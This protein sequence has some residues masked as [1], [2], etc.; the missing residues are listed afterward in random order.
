MTKG[1]TAVEILVTVFVAALLLMSGYQLHSVIIRQ[2]ADTRTMSQASN[3]GYEILR[4][5]SYSAVINPCSN[6]Q[7]TAI[8]GSSIPANGLPAPVSV[9]ISKCRPYNDS[10]LVN[11]IVTVKYGPQNRE[12]SHAMYLTE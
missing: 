8:P 6:P 10:N 4:K 9:T 1:F 7:K 11:V 3:I 5:Q 2:S 12:V